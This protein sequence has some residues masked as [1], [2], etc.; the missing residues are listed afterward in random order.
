[1]LLP[2]GLIVLTG[3][4]V[5]LAYIPLYRPDPGEVGAVISDEA[6]FTIGKSQVNA[7]GLIE[8][9]FFSLFMEGGDV[10]LAASTER[11]KDGGGQLTGSLVLYAYGEQ[12]FGTVGVDGNGSQSIIPI[13]TGCE[14]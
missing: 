6:L 4:G 12:R 8:Q 13:V 10:G 5:L 1:M 3:L 2:V 11:G 7:V 9:K 14:G